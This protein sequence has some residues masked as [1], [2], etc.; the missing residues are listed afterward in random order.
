VAATGDE[1]EESS[2]KRSLESHHGVFLQLHGSE[3]SLTTS[4]LLRDR[5]LCCHT[6]MHASVCFGSCFGRSLERM[7][8]ERS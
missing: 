5:L 1:R 2:R 6:C 4:P 7:G 8:K 3:L